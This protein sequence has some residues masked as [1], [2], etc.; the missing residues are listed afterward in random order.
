MK[1]TTYVVRVVRLLDDGPPAS[2]PRELG[3]SEMRFMTKAEAL[4]WARDA[5][6]TYLAHGETSLALTITEEE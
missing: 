1:P 5:L 4:D 2:R 3:V 6:A